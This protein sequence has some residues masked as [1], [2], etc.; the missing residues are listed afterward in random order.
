MQVSQQDTHIT[1]AVLGN[2]ETVSMGVSNDAA[3]MHIFSATLYTYPKLA[4][5]REIICNAWDAHI[6]AGIT[7]RPIEISVEANRVT[8]RDFGFEN[9]YAQYGLPGLKAVALHYNLPNPIGDDAGT[10][11]SYAS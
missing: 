8:V 10:E 4:T 7:D 5:V 9:N 1:H 3:L 6:A 2:Q 11:D